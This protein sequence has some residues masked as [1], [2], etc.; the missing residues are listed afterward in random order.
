MTQCHRPDLYDKNFQIL[1]VN[2]KNQCF[3]KLW[4]QSH[5]SACSQHRKCYFAQNVLCSQLMHSSKSHLASWDTNTLNFE[6]CKLKL[7][8]IRH[9]F[10]DTTLFESFVPNFL[11][12][13]PRDFCRMFGHIFDWIVCKL[14][15]NKTQDSE[16]ALIDKI[17]AW[18]TFFSLGENINF[19]PDF[20]LLVKVL[21]CFP[22]FHGWSNPVMFS[23]I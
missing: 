4:G 19:P 11:C 10:V 5:L 20:F 18:L 14:H 9:T 3:P 1:N 7:P 12:I 22:L 2:Y 13:F 6:G 16:K 23:I 17:I 8:L 15:I 21:S